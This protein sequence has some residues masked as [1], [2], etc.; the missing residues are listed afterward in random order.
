MSTYPYDSVDQFMSLS[1]A[2]EPRRKGLYEPYFW[3]RPT[4]SSQNSRDALIP[5]LFPEPLPS[6]TFTDRG[7]LSRSR[8]DGDIRDLNFAHG[9]H[10]QLRPEQWRRNPSSNAFT[11]QDQISFGGVNGGTMISVYDGELLLVVQNGGDSSVSPS[12]EQSRPPSSV[13]DHPITE[14]PLTRGPSFRVK[15]GASQSLERKAS[16]ARRNSLPAISHRK[17]FI[18]SEP[19]SEPPLRVLVQAGTLDR[20]V[21]ILAHGLQ[22]VSVSVADDNGEM[23]LREGKTRDLV[24]DRVEF[25][26]VWWHTFRSFVTPLVFFEVSH[27]FPE[28]HIYLTNLN[29]V[30]TK[31]LPSIT[32]SVLV[33]VGS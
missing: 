14:K 2:A 1:L 29:A 9:V 26:K 11:G 24:V 4:T 23:A 19:S 20:L 15:A 7:L 21:N 8:T 27:R 13:A 30:V 12:R 18:P 10:A 3:S 17:N 25:A 31:T 6:L 22:N 16:A 28:F 33:P 5:L 32:T